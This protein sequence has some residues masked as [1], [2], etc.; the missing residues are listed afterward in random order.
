MGDGD[1]SHS[2]TLRHFENG[3]EVK[4]MVFNIQTSHEFI[5]NT[6]GVFLDIYDWQIVNDV[7]TYAYH[8]ATVHCARLLANLR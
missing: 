8:Q 1:A 7:S 2:S 3:Q 4:R 5:S 6:V